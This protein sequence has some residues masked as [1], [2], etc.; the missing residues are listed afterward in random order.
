LTW[1]ADSVA[2]VGYGW[3]GKIS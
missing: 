1:C 3:S 2:V